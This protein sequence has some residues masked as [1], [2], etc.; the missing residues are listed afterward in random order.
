MKILEHDPDTRS[1]I[2]PSIDVGFNCQFNSDQG[3]QGAAMRLGMRTKCLVM[4]VTAVCGLGIVQL[5]AS[6]DEELTLDEPLNSKVSDDVSADKL[7]ALTFPGTSKTVAKR[8]ARSAKSQSITQTSAN[9]FGVSW[10]RRCPFCK[11]GAGA[12]SRIW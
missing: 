8:A 2:L 10:K 7:L 6:S 3:N 9:R 12:D 1:A 4:S 5:L 11:T